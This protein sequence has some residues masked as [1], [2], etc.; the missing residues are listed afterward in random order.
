M[1][2]MMMMIIEATEHRGFWR[3]IR[4]S[5]CRLNNYISITRAM[6][7]SNKNKTEKLNNK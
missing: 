6:K 2:M 1:M 3:T 4:N 7:N 5:R